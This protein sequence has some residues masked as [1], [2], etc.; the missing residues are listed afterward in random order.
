MANNKTL[1]A[2]NA[3]NILNKISIFDNLTTAE[4]KHSQTSTGI[5]FSTKLTTI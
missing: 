3:F 2:D 4:K 5:L 1:S